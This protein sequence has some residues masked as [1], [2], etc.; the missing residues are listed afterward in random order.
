MRSP[1]ADKEMVPVTGS[2][3]AIVSQFRIVSTAQNK[4]SLL[5]LVVIDQQFGR[6]CS[7]RGDRQTKNEASPGRE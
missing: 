1:S 7:R 3:A 4:D 6:R 5:N 2:G